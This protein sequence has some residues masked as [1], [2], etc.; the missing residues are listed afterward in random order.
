M[1]PT[2]TRPPVARRR[3]RHRLATTS[4]FAASLLAGLAAQHP[5]ATADA[6]PPLVTESSSPAVAGAATQARTTLGM[7]QRTGS[8]ALVRRYVQERTVVATMVAD[9][10]GI[11]AV[12]LDEAW[13][14]ADQAHE[15]AVL[16]A[17]S[18]LGTPYRYLP[19]RRA[20]RRVRLHG[21]H[22][23]GVGAGRRRAHAPE[24]RPDRCGGSS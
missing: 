5:G 9:E 23:V 19:G 13:I 24:R 16:S 1:H 10:L 3:L 4:V 7:A 11:D 22:E 15:I 8:P 14:R 21:S 2:T 20:V 6:A 12:A 18:Q 17:L